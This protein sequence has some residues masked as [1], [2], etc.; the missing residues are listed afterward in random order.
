[1]SNS[2]A[3]SSDKP[4]RHRSFR[5]TRARA[6]VLSS[7]MTETY[8]YTIPRSPR[9]IAL[10]FL[11]VALGRVVYSLLHFQFSIADLIL[12]AFPAIALCISRLYRDLYSYDL[13]DEVID[14]GETLLVRNEGMEDRIYISNI[15]EVVYIGYERP[16]RVVL[17]LRESTPFGKQIVF[18]PRY[19]PL[20]ISNHPIA[21]DLR[22]RMTA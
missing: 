11:V 19:Q 15:R 2:S 5:L 13:V 14:E 6:P 8:K 4:Q 10:I 3:S 7:S 17:W 1:M 9:V 22:N 16:Q 18:M 21:T 20:C 12:F